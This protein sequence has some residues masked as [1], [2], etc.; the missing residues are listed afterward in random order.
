M[1]SPARM[2]LLPGGVRELVSAPA[3]RSRT[4]SLCRTGALMSGKYGKS[5]EQKR[6]ITIEQ[7]DKRRD[8]TL[9]SLLSLPLVQHPSY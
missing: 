8:S 6:M 5:L 9:F 2:S 7:L 4:A 3:I 1:L